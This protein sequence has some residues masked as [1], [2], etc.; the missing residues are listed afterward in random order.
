MATNDFL[1]FGATAGLNILT[2]AQYAALPAET[3]GFLTGVAQ[4]TQLNKVWRQGST[5]ASMLGEFLKQANLDALDDGNPPTTSLL[6]NFIAAI[7]SLIHAQAAPLGVPLPYF[8]G[9]APP[10]YV[11][12][13]TAN[14]TFLRSNA[15]FG[16]L[17]TTFGPGDGSTTAGLPNMAG[18]SL[19]GAD[20]SGSRIGS[21]IGGTAAL[22]TIAGSQFPQSHLH[23]NNLSDPGHSHPNYLFDPGHAHPSYIVDPSHAHSATVLELYGGSGAGSGTPGYVPTGITTSN[24]TT[25][26][27]IVNAGSFTNSS[28]VNAAASANLTLNNASAFIGNQGN[29][30]PTLFVNWMLRLN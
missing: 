2:N 15:L 18:I 23:N 25:G 9:S 5:M 1:P 11:L 22:N 30:P 6:P 20:P 12:C 4:S 27:Y 26:V 19:S 28:V 29:I 24:N 14:N 17:G 3:G 7:N 8:G 16:V 10:G 13:M 21:A